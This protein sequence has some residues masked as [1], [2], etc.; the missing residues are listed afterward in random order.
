MKVDHFEDGYLDRLAQEREE[1]DRRWG[2]P[3]FT[4]PILRVNQPTGNGRI[5]P[6]TICREMIRRFDEGTPDSMMG[7]LGMPPESIIHLTNVSHVVK[8]LEI[9][10][11]TLYATIEVLRT[12]QGRVLKSMMDAD[13]TMVSFRTRGIGNGEVNEDN[14]LVVDEQYKLITIDALASNVAATI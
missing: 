13:P 9:K 12:P 1:E 10:E 2:K 6:E 8:K 7:E 14:H 4:V 11:G 5:Y 3:V